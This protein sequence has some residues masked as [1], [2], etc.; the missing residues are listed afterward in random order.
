MRTTGR[1]ALIAG[2]GLLLA[3]CTGTAPP[4]E[5]GIGG[6]VTLWYLEDPD[7]AFM[8]A[9]KEG[10]EATYPGTTVELTELPED[11]F[12]TKVD[13]ALLANQPPDVAFVYEPRWMKAGDILPLG[14]TIAEYDIDTD[15]MNAVALSECE[16]DGELYCLGSLTGSV[17]LVYNKDLFDEAGVDYPS[18]DEPWTVDEY[19]DAARRVSASLG[20]VWGATAE[21]PFTWM[22]RRTHFSDDGTMIEGFVDDPAT[23]HVYDVLTGLAKDGAAPPPAETELATAA[24]MLAAGRVAMAVTDTEYAAASLVQAGARWGVAPPPVEKAGDAPFV[25]VGTDKYGAFSD[26][27][28]PDTARALVA[29]IATEGNRLRVDVSDKPP[30]DSR[31]LP[32]WAGDDE[33]RQETVE[34]VSLRSN[35]GLFVPGF[36]EVTA[37]LFDYYAQMANGDVKPRDAI[38][39]QA[40]IMQ[41]KLDREWQTWEEIE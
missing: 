12:V 5:G 19:A 30:L 14:D 29:Y 3:G 40:P 13:T 39:E 11:G 8:P 25:F 1:V 35:P 2:M 23:I 18:T 37:P 16:L 7:S 27:S 9:I 20:G 32:E 22:D 41:E 10:F 15:A 28:N 38:E 36:W 26:S 17:T 24:D 21:A 6:T 33:G 31:L 4:A 34:V